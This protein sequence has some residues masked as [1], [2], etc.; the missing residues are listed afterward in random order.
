MYVDSKESV[1]MSS[2]P[3]P[4]DVDTKRH[5]ESIFQT[6]VESLIIRQSVIYT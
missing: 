6:V 5:H 4:F 3:K 1:E 2:F